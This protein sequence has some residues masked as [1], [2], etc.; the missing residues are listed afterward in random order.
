MIKI[1][2]HTTAL[3]FISIAILLIGCAETKE[4]NTTLT[5]TATAYNSVESQTKKGNVG[6]AAWGRYPSPW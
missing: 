4:K 1:K 6:L 3:A 5:V 2:R